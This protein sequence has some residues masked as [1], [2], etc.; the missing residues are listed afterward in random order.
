MTTYIL[1][2]LGIIIVLLLI[3]VF[4]KQTVDISTL[5]EDNSRLRERLA[6]R[7]GM[8]SQNAIELKNISADLANFK[9]ILILS[10]THNTHNN[11]I[12]T[13]HNCVFNTHNIIISPT[14]K[15]RK[16]KFKVF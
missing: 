15:V 6:E 4:R 11:L 2:L 8:L 13:T 16:L 14:L 10:N 7:L 5:H 12:H 9:D 1:S 3:L